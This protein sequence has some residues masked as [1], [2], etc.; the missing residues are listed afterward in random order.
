[1]SLPIEYFGGNSGRYFA[2]GS[3]ELVPGNSA[4]GPTFA[5]SHGV[6]MNASSMGPDLG[7][8][9]NHSGQQTGGGGGCG[10]SGTPPVLPASGGGCGWKNDNKG[11]KQKGGR[12]TMPM[13]YFGG[14]PGGR[15]EHAPSCQHS[16]GPM[17]VNSIGNNLGPCPGQSGTLTGG[18]KRRSH[19]K[20]RL[21]RSRKS[22][23]TSSRRRKS[24]RGG[25]RKA[26]KSSK[27]RKGRKAHKG[28]KGRRSGRKS[29]K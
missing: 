20:K 29:R 16:Y 19:S 24:V 7:P 8:F 25:A 1:M 22:T 5:S 27:G 13:E 10:C 9:P 26:R 11:R 14:N 12:V 3:P 18:G 28:S 2:P 15:F 17:P 21:H 4:Y 23:K 6:S